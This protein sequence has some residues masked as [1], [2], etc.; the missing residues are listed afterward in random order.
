ML[1]YLLVLLLLSLGLRPVAAQNPITDE[2]LASQ[3]LKQ[4]LRGQYLHNDTAQA[5]I[6]LYSRRQ[7]GGVSW[8]VGATLSALRL[9]LGTGSTSNPGNSPYYTTGPDGSGNLGGAFLIATPLAGY[10]LAKLLHYSNA[11]LQTVLTNYAAGQP[12]PRAL[13]RKLK[14]RFFAAP[15]VKYKAVTVKPAP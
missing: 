15:I 9:G 7:A 6:T 5:I 14:P 2:S 10:G 13:R 12:L 1:K 11:H 8:M 4:R 3:Q